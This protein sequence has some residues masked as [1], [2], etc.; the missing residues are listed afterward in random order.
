MTVLRGRLGLLDLVSLAGILAGLGISIYLTITHYQED[1]LVCAVGGDCE[2]VQ[3]S[4]YSTVGPIP[5]AMLG[6]LLMTTLLGLWVVRRVRPDLATVATG[7]SF[8]A[9]LAG[10]ASE[11]YLTYVEIWVLEAICQWCVAF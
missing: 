7:L 3:Q 11:G 10:V 6:I 5:V 9:L 1:L 2:T 8:A 4:K